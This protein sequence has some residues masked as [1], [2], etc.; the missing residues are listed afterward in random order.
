[1]VEKSAHEHR[2][3]FLAPSIERMVALEAER[4]A[5]LA[6]AQ[7]TDRERRKAEYRRMVKAR[8]RSKG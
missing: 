3:A 4:Q 1:M 2:R 5:G 6:E 8:R 7:R